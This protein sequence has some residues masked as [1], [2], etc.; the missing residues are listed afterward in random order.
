MLC[1]NTIILVQDLNYSPINASNEIDII[2]FH[3]KTTK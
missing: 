3:I 1:E 2:T